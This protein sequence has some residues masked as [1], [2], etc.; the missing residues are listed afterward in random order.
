MTPALPANLNTDRPPTNEIVVLWLSMVGVTDRVWPVTAYNL[1]ELG[2]PMWWTGLPGA[3]H[4]IG[5]LDGKWP[6][7]WR[8][9][10]WT[11]LP[12]P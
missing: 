9:L 2:K 12:S 5:R 3:Y 7:T 1:P 4:R 10:G 8:L 6:A 11:P